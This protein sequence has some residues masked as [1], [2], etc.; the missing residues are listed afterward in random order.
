MSDIEETGWSWRKSLG[1]EASRPV[2]GIPL[3]PGNATKK[4]WSCFVEW[5]SRSCWLMLFG[6]L[7]MSILNRIAPSWLNRYH[8]ARDLYRNQ[9]DNSSLDW[10]TPL[11]V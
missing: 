5:A 6:I 10:Q 2:D 9:G 4:Q 3:R 1:K 11:E 8:E 7:E